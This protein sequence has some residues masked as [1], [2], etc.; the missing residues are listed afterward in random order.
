MARYH[1]PLISRAFVSLVQRIDEE[2]PCGVRITFQTSEG[3]I[4]TVM[5]KSVLGRFVYLL[6]AA[7]GCCSTLEH[8]AIKVLQADFVTFF[9][10]TPTDMGYYVH[11]LSRGDF[12]D[13]PGIA[14]S[15]DYEDWAFQMPNYHAKSL[16]D[17]LVGVCDSMKVKD[18]R[19]TKKGKRK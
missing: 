13:Y 4:S 7:R 5:T 11:S 18:M 1:C 17:V 16:Y 8:P 3:T 12:G 9:E 2:K 6:N 10:D 15:C 19:P 14:F